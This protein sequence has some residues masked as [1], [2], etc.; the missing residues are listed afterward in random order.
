M[1]DPATVTVYRSFL[2]FD[3]YHEATRGL[4]VDVHKAHRLTMSPFGY[5]MPEK[6]FFTGYA[7]TGAHPDHRV[8]Q[9]ILWALNYSQVSHPAMDNP[10]PPRVRLIL[11]AD[12]PPDFDDDRCAAWT[13]ALAAPPSTRKH[14]L[15]A[16]EGDTVEYQIIVEPRSNIRVDGI[17]KTKVAKH[18]NDINNWWLRK[19][20]ASGLTL[21]NTPTIDK[22]GKATSAAKNLTINHHRIT[23]KA[24]ITDPARYTQAARQGIGPAK[25]YGCGLLLTK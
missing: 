14:T 9:N 7:A 19:A 5:A 22:S 11:Q 21:N 10:P 1:T 15:T 6:D 20:E 18:H 24:T 8:S 2:E 4:L 23:G 3:A 16:A 25:A 13:P 12:I 17:K